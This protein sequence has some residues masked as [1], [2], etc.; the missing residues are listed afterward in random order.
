[1]NNGAFA[2]Q[3]RAH[4]REDDFSGTGGVKGF[5]AFI[6][7]GKNLHPN[8]FAA[9]GE[10][11]GHEYSVEVAMQWNSGYSEQ[12]LCFTNNTAA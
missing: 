7:K 8:V 2:P 12:V 3:G 1:L 6:N 11:P 9:M 10:R 5:V 4:R